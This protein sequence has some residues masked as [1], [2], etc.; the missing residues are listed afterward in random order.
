MGGRRTGWVTFEFMVVWMW[1]EKTE[2]KPL[3]SDSL[4]TWAGVGKCCLGLNI[5]CKLPQP[6]WRANNQNTDP[7]DGVSYLASI[8]LH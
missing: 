3:Q 7:C 1:G 8:L 2:D 6:S 4:S 5:Y